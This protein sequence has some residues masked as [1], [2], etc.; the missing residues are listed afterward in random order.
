MVI[1]CIHCT[2]TIRN[3]HLY[4]MLY[5]FVLNMKSYKLTNVNFLYICII[6]SFELKYERL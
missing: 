2:M 1:H 6:K 5:E 4:G 3:L